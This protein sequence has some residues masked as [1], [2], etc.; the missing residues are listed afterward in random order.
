MGFR[1]GK[2]TRDAIFQLR[3]ACE[4]SL[5]MNKNIYL[6]FID[7]QKAFDRVSH[8]KL[9]EIME[10]AGIP[11]LERRLI[12]NLYWDQEANIRWEN[13]TTR[14]I[15]TRKEVRQGCILSPILFKLFSEFMISEALDEV[16]GILFNEVNITN[17]RY[18]DD[19]VLAAYS[20]KKLQMMLD[21]LNMTCN[22]YGMAINVKKTKVMVVC[23]NGKIKCNVT[24]DKKIL[25]QVS[26]YK[27]L[28][29]CITEDA[30]CEEEIKTRIAMARGFLEEQ[31]VVKKK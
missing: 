21:K 5:E 26:H 12:I 30:R 13:E 28:G 3:T 8:D 10:K 19:A 16:E 6:C 24:L 15:K 22:K 2:G 20:K 14:T 11:E 1:K 29:S 23:K 7:Y 9:V 4:R 17:F 27:Y 25:E 31:R 18:A